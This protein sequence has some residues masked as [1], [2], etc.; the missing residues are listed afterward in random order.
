MLV[1]KNFSWIIYDNNGDIIEFKKRVKQRYIDGF[2]EDFK[3]RN[4]AH[5]D[6]PDKK[7]YAFENI[8]LEQSDLGE[9]YDDFKKAYE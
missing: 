6:E 1:G 5:A 2:R 3:K 4:F 8:K 9:F 7:K